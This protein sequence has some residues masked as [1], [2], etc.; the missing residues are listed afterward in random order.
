MRRCSQK[1]L[2]L[3]PPKLLWAT[4][5]GKGICWNHSGTLS[6]S[7]PSSVLTS[8]AC[9]PPPSVSS[10]LS[11]FFSFSI[12]CSLLLSH[13]L[14]LVPSQS[15]FPCDTLCPRPSLRPPLSKTPIS[16]SPP[17][18]HSQEN[19]HNQHTQINAHPVTHTHWQC[20]C[21]YSHPSQ[22][23]LQ[24][25]YPHLLL[26]PNP[27]PLPTLILITPPPPSSALISLHQICCDSK[28]FPL[29]CDFTARL[30]LLHLHQPTYPS[31]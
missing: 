11:F 27:T 2:K 4:K 29:I 24:C 15:I 9:T 26:S 12:K 31:Q 23:L 21:K 7:F 5:E 16:S 10:A 30:R 14:F 3:P 25:T 8:T 20:A 17:P 18:P 6:T 19:I 22:N 28:Q 1:P 13:P